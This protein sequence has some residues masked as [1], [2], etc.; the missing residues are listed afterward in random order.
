MMEYRGKIA[1]VPK[2]TTTEETET[3][4]IPVWTNGEIFTYAIVDKEDFLRLSNGPRWHLHMRGYATRTIGRKKIRQ[5]LHREVLGY[6]GKKSVDHIDRNP[7][8]CQKKNLRI[9]NQGLNSWANIQRMESRLSAFQ[10]HLTDT[11]I[12]SAVLRNLPE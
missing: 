4:K 3:E 7:L 9:I 2:T 5:Y 10:R 6:S 8:N 12:S 11:F 1:T